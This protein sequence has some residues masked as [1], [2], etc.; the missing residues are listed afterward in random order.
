MMRTVVL[1][2][3]LV[4]AVPAVAGAAEDAHG[5]GTTLLQWVAR[6]MNFLIFAGLIFW[7]LRKADAFGALDEKRE[8][9]EGELR[10]AQEMHLQAEKRL[11]EVEEILRGLEDEVKGIRARAQEEA[12]AQKARI[13]ER[14]K[15]EVARIVATAERQVDA[16]TREAQRHLRAHAADLATQMAAEMVREEI[17]PE[18]RDRLFDDYVRLLEGQS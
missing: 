18:D 9:V 1:A 10:R 12:E 17:Q 13:L 15:E 6:V 3:L 8:Q 2:L 14:A 11:G 7:A 4:V 16:E 5:G